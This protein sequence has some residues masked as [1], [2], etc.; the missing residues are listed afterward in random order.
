MGEEEAMTDG[1]IICERNRGRKV[2]D[3]VADS[4]RTEPDVYQVLRTAGLCRDQRPLR[5]YVVTVMVPELVRIHAVSPG[6]AKAEAA[7][8]FNGNAKVTGV[9]ET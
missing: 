4:G 5:D 7:R 3:I 2:R 9:V 1:R 6:Q 8:L